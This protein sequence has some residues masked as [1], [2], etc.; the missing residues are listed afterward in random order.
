MQHKNLKINDCLLT[1]LLAFHNES[2]AC[3]HRLTHLDRGKVNSI[4]KRSQIH[5]YNV[6]STF[7][8][9]LQPMTVINWWQTNAEQNSDNGVA[10]KEGTARRE[11]KKKWQ[12]SIVPHI[13]VCDD[14]LT[15]DTLILIISLWLQL[16]AADS[17]QG[18]QEGSRAWG[19]LP[20]AWRSLSR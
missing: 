13:Q 6:S 19:S 1:E 8:L 11:S 14:F 10:Y 17:V 12:L 15:R 9:Q 4:E 18:P 20:A 16:G 2:G 3:D 7:C 5:F